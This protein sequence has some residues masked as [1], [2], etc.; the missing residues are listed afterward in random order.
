MCR[1]A[2]VIQ[3]GEAKIS[4]AELKNFL[5][6]MEYFGRDACGIAYLI[7][8]RIQYCKETGAPSQVIGPDFEENNERYCREATAILIHTRQAT[9]GSPKD[10]VN[11]HP[12]FGDKY[13]I[14]HNGIVQTDMVYKADGETDTEQLLRSMEKHGITAGLNK[15]AGMAAVIM[16]N[17]LNMN[18]VYFYK[19]KN[20]SMSCAW[21]EPNHI[22]FIASEMAIINKSVIGRTVEEYSMVSDN[23]YQFILSSDTC[24]IISEPK[25]KAW[26]WFNR[27]KNSDYKRHG[28]VYVGNNPPASNF[29]YSNGIPYYNNYYSNTAKDPGTIRGSGSMK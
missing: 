6:N 12:I 7:G 23:L 24:R 10:R 2:A 1:V 4:P 8:D 11:N 14:I 25:L 18:E 3:T 21:D 27:P 16:F 5:L 13:C 9:H 28:K 29:V 22:L 20:A 19:S 15:C 17:L 26:G